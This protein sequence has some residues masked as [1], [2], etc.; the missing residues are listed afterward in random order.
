MLA[1]PVGRGAVLGG[2]AVRRAGPCESRRE[3]VVVVA[4]EVGGRIVEVKLGVRA[5]VV[6]CFTGVCCLLAMV[7]KEGE[8]E[9][10]ESLVPRSMMCEGFV[11]SLA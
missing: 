11:A 8:N 10:S 4:A 2:A 7:L 5:L 9:R 1:L 6:D 3:G